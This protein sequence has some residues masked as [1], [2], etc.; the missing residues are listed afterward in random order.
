[1]HE[2][3]RERYVAEIAIRRSTEETTEWGKLLAGQDDEDGGPDIP[4]RD[5]GQGFGPRLEGLG[6]M[7]VQEAVSWS[8]CMCWPLKIYLHVP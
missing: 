6:C 2:I 5:V 3:E 1:M 4:N 7:P 8:Q